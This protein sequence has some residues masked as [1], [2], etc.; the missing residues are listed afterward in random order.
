MHFAYLFATKYETLT[1]AAFLLVGS[2]TVKSSFLYII[3]L[4]LEKKNT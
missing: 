1:A 4:S 3:N 2:K